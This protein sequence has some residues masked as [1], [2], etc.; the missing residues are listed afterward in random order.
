MAD[1]IVD[2][3]RRISSPPNSVGE[4]NLREKFNVYAGPVVGVLAPITLTRYLFPL[5]THN[6]LE[7]AAYWACAAALSLPL[8]LPSFVSLTVMGKVG[9][10]ELAA[11]RL[12]KES[13]LSELASPEESK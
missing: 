3:F 4:Y 7:S 13:Q 5:E 12:Q 11:K 6:I 1:R 10:N 9:A 2:G 8:Q